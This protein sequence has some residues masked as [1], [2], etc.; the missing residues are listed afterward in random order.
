M[1]IL[2]FLASWGESCPSSSYFM[3]P[4]LSALFRFFP[5]PYCARNELILKDTMKFDCS[6]CKDIYFSCFFPLLFYL[7]IDDLMSV[8]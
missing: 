6:W 3:T 2:V 1:G 5:I 8:S 4:G 7:G